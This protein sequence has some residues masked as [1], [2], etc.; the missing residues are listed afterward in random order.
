MLKSYKLLIYDRNCRRYLKEIQDKNQFHV[1]KLRQIFTK[2]NITFSP[3]RNQPKNMLNDGFNKCKFCVLCLFPS[4]RR[5]G[6]CFKSFITP[7]EL[8]SLCFTNFLCDIVAYR[9]ENCM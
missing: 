2:Y 5:I 9:I 8:I 1:N 4:I 6:G 3:N 7:L